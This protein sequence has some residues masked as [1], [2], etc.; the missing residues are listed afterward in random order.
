MI[1]SDILKT[2]PLPRL[3]T[4]VLMAFLLKKNREFLLTHPE[5]KITPALFKKY[6]ILTRK[7]LAG[8]SIAVLTGAKEFYGREFVVDK[9][10]LVPRPETELL[11]EEVLDSIKKSPINNGV[12]L[13]DIGTG[14]G[15]II[16][17]LAL[18]I[19]RQDK[20]RFNEILFR[21]IDISTGALKI[22]LKNYARHKQSKNIKFLQ[23]NLIEPLVNKGDLSHLFNDHLFI[24]ANLPYL[25]P[26]QVSSSPSIKKEPRL[27]LIAGRDGLKYYRQLFKQIAVVW[28][29]RENNPKRSIILFC[30]IDPSQAEPI[31]NLAKEILPQ[32]RVV[33]K[34]DLAGRKR[35]AI[36]SL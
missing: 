33:I 36:I 9:N 15:A 5:I 29:D 7:R 31:T 34:K 6:Q 35:L 28:R 32:P 13:V 11:V 8:W 30:E 22:A 18:E 21:G 25:T 10:V 17:S 4:E 14:S 20:K 24:A 3:E 16:I 23:G 1:F 2:S 19:F 12:L 27:A 26:Q